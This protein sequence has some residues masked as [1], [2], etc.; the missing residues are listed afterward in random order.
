MS[1]HVGRQWVIA[2]RI[3]TLITL[4]AGLVNVIQFLLHLL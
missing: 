1:K 2:E 3:G 4:V